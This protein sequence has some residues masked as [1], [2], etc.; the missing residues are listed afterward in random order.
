MR[1]AVDLEFE[2]AVEGRHW[3]Q[4]ARLLRVCGIVSS[5]GEVIGCPGSPVPRGELPGSLH[6]VIDN[7]YD[8]PPGPLDRAC[9]PP[10]H[11]TGTDHNRS[12]N[13]AGSHVDVF[14]RVR[15]NAVAY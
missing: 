3:L 4:D 10:A 13:F 14:L 1:D 5:G 2:A 9:M 15:A 6:V 12:Q 11:Q 7:G 8:R